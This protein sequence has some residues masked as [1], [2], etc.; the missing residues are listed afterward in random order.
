MPLFQQNLMLRLDLRNSF[1]AN[2]IR[3]IRFVHLVV[4]LLLS[5]SEAS[6]GATA[7]VAEHPLSVVRVE[8]NRPKRAMMVEKHRAR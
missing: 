5:G 6:M 3:I 1:Q 2:E 7:Q 8:V 4:R